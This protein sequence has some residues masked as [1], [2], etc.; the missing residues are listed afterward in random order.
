MIDCARLMLPPCR[1]S[2]RTRVCWICGGV[3]SIG[4]GIICIAACMFTPPPRLPPPPPRYLNTSLRTKMPMS[5]SSTTTMRMN[6]IM[7][8]PPLLLGDPTA[9]M[10]PPTHEPSLIGPVGDRCWSAN[11]PRRAIK[12]QI[13]RYDAPA[14][15][16]S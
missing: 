16:G 3:S 13:M 2:G 14:T 1:M 8:R 9:D 12:A 11:A 15:P 6:S 10:A 5:S 4:L 7:T